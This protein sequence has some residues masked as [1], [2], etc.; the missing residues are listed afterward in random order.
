APIHRKNRIKKLAEGAGHIVL[1]LPTYSPDLN[2]IE[3][4]FSA[5]KRLRMY[6]PAGT[7]IDEIICKYCAS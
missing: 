6:A 5:L 4:D 7:T 2:D 3:H 1:F